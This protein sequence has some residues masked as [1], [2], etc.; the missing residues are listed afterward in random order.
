MGFSNIALTHTNARLSHDKVHAFFHQHPPDFALALPHAVEALARA[1]R[2]ALSA[3]RTRSPSC[4]PAASTGGR[5][6]PTGAGA[7]PRLQAVVVYRL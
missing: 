3:A 6:E 2:R 5:P 4:S 7:L 1:R